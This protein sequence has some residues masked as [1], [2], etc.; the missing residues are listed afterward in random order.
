MYYSTNYNSPI[1][2]MM[3]A[4]DGEAICGVWF[5]GQ[6]HFKS[7]IADEIVEDSDLAIF[8]DV[9]DFFD[10]YF[11]GLKPEITFP[12]KPHGSEFRKKVWKILTQIPYGETLIL[13]FI[14][15]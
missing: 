3:I 13:I 4:S 7:S 10:D 9:F 8:S 1:G 11:K 6:K 15:K 12:L 5:Y 14:I 2:R